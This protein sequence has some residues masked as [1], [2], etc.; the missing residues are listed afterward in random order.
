[1]QVVTSLHIDWHSFFNSDIY[2]SQ[3]VSHCFQEALAGRYQVT[4]TPCASLPSPMYYAH[5]TSDDDNVYVSGGVSLNK[6]TV[7]RVYQYIL[8]EDKWN[9]L[10]V[11]RQYYGIPQVVNGKLTL[12]G[13]RDMTS[14]K[15]TNQVSTF[16]NDDSK[17]HSD[18][19]DMLVPRTRPAVA[20]HMNDMI[21]AGGKGEDTT[22]VLDDIEVLSTSEHQWQKL[23]TRLPKPMWGISATASKKYFH[24]VGYNGADN[25]C[26]NDAYTIAIDHVTYQ[27]AVKPLSADQGSMK[28]QNPWVSLPDAPL[29]YCALV[30]TS[31]PPVLLGGEDKNGELVATATIYEQATQLWRQV[32][33]IKLPTGL[34][35]TTVAQAGKHVIIVI[36]GCTNTNTTQDASST[37]LDTVTKIE[38]KPVA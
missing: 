6:D 7:H 23:P 35:Y 31:S 26:Y 16:H 8:K 37:S 29:W 12:F 9:I 5:A 28:A 33:P 36:G 21:V 30:P 17:W 38:F 13:G 2:L 19:P 34:A 18:Y 4:C 1:M 15:V 11:P 27:S 14:G 32:D 22:V 25:H 3:N 24:I 20:G 10:P